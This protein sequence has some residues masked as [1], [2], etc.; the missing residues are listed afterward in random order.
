MEV[1]RLE[2]YPSFSSIWSPGTVAV[3]IALVRVFNLNFLKAGMAVWTA[4]VRLLLSTTCTGW[5]LIGL[6]RFDFNLN[7][8]SWF[9]LEDTVTVR[10]GAKRTAVELGCV[11]LKN[12]IFAM[13]KFNVT[14]LKLG[15]AGLTHPIQ[16]TLYNNSA[17]TRIFIL[18]KRERLGNYARRESSP[19]YLISEPKQ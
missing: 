15:W 9:S 2:K 14:F 17:H 5:G 10:F 8:K 7:W 4:P 13:C 3:H 6:I 19:N 18:K 12:L 1:L 16:F 11:N